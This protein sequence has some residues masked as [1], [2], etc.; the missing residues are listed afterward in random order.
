MKKPLSIKTLFRSK[1]KTLV[2]FLLVAAVTFALF[3]Q[4]A[5]FAVT[6]R[7]L[8]K[9]SKNYLGV[10]AIEK[11]PVPDDTALRTS[12]DTYL[13]ADPRIS[14]EKASDYWYEPLTNDEIKEIQSMPN[15]DCVDLRYMTAGISDDYLRPDDGSSY[16]SGIKASFY[17]YTARIVVEGTLTDIE[18]GT[19]YEHPD[20]TNLVNRL[21]LSD[22]KL[23]AGDLTIDI[24]GGT[25]T[26]SGNMYTDENTNIHIFWDLR[27]T[28][29]Y[30]SNFLW[31]T[32]YVKNMTIG[33]RYVFIARHISAHVRRYMDK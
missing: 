12:D 11:S 28:T 13:A 17:N 4:V 26:M 10:G 23:L 32:E 33:D 19:P 2:T 5:E 31:D 7:E 16:I 27:L 14:G 24:D 25:V 9:L 18:I 15:M 8:D 21:T 20:S 29:R 30:T 3:S 22:C 1:L 6:S